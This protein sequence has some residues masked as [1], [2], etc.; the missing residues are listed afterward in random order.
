MEFDAAAGGVAS[1]AGCGALALFVLIVAVSSVV[2][3]RTRRIPNACVL[4]GACLWVAA[5]V[6]L[7][8]CSGSVSAV[9]AEGMPPWGLT[10]PDGIVG[11]AVLG[12]GVLL[13]TVAFEALSGRAAMGGGDIKLLAVV[14]L[15]LGW[16]RGLACLFAACVVSVA[17][18]FMRRLAGS[19]DA[20]TFPFAPAILVG[21]VAALFL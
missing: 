2:D 20:A 3:F 4:A 7:G 18:S 8:A 9:F 19:P 14:G 13:A 15:F 1:L 16:E 21:I 10:A 5:R 6:V 17:V 11:A 12:G